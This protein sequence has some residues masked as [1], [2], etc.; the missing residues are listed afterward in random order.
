M[1]SQVHIAVT[2]DFNPD[3]AGHQATTQALQHAADS[4]GLDVIGDWIPTRSTD[5][6]AGRARL[7]RYDGIFSAGGAY[8]SKDGAI[9]AI[10]FAREQGWPFFGT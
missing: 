1:N 9:Q 5:T 4:L 10:R 8:A 2:S 7:S 6:E 3:N